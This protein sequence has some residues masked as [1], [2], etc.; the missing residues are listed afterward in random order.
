MNNDGKID[1]NGDR[2]IVGYS[3]PNFTM[4]MSNTLTYKNFELYFLLNWISGGGKN[5]YYIADN[6]YANYVGTFGG[7]GILLTG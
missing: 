5:N 4:T 1:A 2:K 6:I 3:K 7:G